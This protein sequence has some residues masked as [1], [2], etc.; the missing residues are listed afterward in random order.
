MEEESKFITATSLLQKKLTFLETAQTLAYLRL[1]HEHKKFFKN[2]K[3]KYIKDE[4][5]GCFYCMQDFITAAEALIQSP[6]DENYFNKKLE[7]L[8]F[9]ATLNKSIIEKP[10]GQ[11]IHWLDWASLYSFIKNKYIN[12]LFRFLIES[13]DSDYSVPDKRIFIEVV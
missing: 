13:I 5:N 3:I 7:K 9:W 1:K 10:E 8:Y 11:F 4:N 2:F 6:R 12:D